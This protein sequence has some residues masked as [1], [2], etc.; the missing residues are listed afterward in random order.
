MLEELAA[1]NMS[2]QHIFNA[3]F[4]DLC[5]VS[6]DVPFDKVGIC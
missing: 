2:D 6:M 4:S 1:T 3:A 5:L